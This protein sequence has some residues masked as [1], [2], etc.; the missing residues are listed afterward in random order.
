MRM[1]CIGT[2]LALPP[3]DGPPPRPKPRDGAKAGI[4]MLPCGAP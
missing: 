4:G 2:V 1:R 3:I